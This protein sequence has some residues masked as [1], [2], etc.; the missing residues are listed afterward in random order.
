MHDGRQEQNVLSHFKSWVL[1]VDRASK[2]LKLD[3]I[4][5]ATPESDRRNLK[6]ATGKYDYEQFGPD[7]SLLQQVQA[8]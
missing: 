3:E 1:S 6:I 2:F 4:P 7:Q 8:P 5:E